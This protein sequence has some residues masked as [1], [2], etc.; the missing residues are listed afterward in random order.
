[1]ASNAVAHQ[2]QGLLATGAEHRHKRRSGYIE[3]AAVAVDKKVVA[4]LGTA[5]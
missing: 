4:G 3:V 2:G 1:M 5:G